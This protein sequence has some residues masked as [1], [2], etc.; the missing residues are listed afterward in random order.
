MTKKPRDIT[1]IIQQINIPTNNINR[2]THNKEIQQQLSKTTTPGTSG[3]LALRA[4]PSR[5]HGVNPR[6]FRKEKRKK[7]KRKAAG[8]LGEGTYNAKN[9]E[10]H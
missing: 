1:K 8:G 6:I 2:P 7:K 9:E 4:A 3:T 5:I 10:L